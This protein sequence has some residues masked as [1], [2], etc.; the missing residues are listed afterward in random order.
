MN[1]KIDTGSNVF[2]CPITTKKEPHEA[3]WDFLKEFYPCKTTRQM[4]GNEGEDERI[5]KDTA[6]G[7]VLLVEGHTECISK[8]GVIS[9]VADNNSTDVYFTGKDL[10]MWCKLKYEELEALEL[11][12]GKKMDMSELAIANRYSKKVSNYLHR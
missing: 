4:S 11:Y 12:Y 8:I 1:I 6:F 10:M 2:Y 9:I 3:L 7:E 5:L